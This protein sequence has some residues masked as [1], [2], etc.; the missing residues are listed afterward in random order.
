MAALSL[1]RFSLFRSAALPFP[2]SR[3]A[4]KKSFFDCLTVVSLRLD[5]A[6]LKFTIETT[7]TLIYEKANNDCNDSLCVFHDGKIN[8]AGQHYSE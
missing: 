7:A 4:V 3:S 1:F 6:A 5:V 8:A 2:F